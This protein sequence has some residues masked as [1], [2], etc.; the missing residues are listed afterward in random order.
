MTLPHLHFL[1][2]RCPIYDTPTFA[3]FNEKMSLILED[4]N[5]YTIGVFSRDPSTITSYE[6]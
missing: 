4:S 6:P 5:H 3:F 2:R 1:L